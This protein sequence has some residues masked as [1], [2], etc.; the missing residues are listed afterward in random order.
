[1]RIFVQLAIATVLG[2][3]ASSAGAARATQVDAA[4]SSM[5][6]QAMVA[7]PGHRPAADAASL[8]GVYGLPSGQLLRVS[9]QGRRLFAELGER[10]GELVPVGGDRFAIRGSSVRLT[11]EVAPFATDV[12]ITGH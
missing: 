3:A 2:V 6:L 9:Y 7:V 1:M 12:V 8:A 4:P 11:F 10:K 5:S